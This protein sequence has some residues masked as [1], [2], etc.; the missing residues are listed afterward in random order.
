M[1]VELKVLKAR[2]EENAETVNVYVKQGFRILRW[3]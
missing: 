1:K 3:N 2:A